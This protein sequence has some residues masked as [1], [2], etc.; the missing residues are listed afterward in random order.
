MRRR[1]PHLFDE[2]YDGVLSAM[3]LSGGVAT[4]D[5]LAAWLGSATAARALLQTVAERRLGSCIVL[6]GTRALA[7]RR[8]TMRLLVDRESP[9]PVLARTRFTAVHRFEYHLREGRPLHPTGWVEPSLFARGPL[10]HPEVA[11]AMWAS[12]DRLDS[13]FIDLAPD[14]SRMALIDRAFA[15]RHFR[16]L[17]DALGIVSSLVGRAIDLRIVCGSPEQ[18]TRVM[19]ALGEMTGPTPGVTAHVVEYDIGRAFNLPATVTDD[20]PTAP[21][22]SMA[23]EPPGGAETRPG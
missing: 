20:S 16:R 10:R 8:T 7:L 15:A 1:D 21:I 17:F 2:Q 14:G 22:A 11:D 13:V 3:S 23:P 6:P 12:L 9:R 4:I 5:Q 19:R 18:A